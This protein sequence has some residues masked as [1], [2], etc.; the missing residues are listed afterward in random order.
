M[1]KSA[2][3]DCRNAIVL[4]SEGHY[5]IR[6]GRIRGEET[7]R[8]GSAVL[9]LVNDLERELK[10]ANHLLAAMEQVSVGDT[11]KE[12]LNNT[13][14]FLN[15]FLPYDRM[16]FSL[17]EDNGTMLRQCWTRPI[18]EEDGI[19]AGYSCPLNKS[20]LAQ[21][22]STRKPRIIDDLSAYLCTHSNSES[23]KLLIDQGIC[24]NLACPVFGRAGPIGFFFFD[25]KTEGIYRQEHVSA[26]SKIIGQL[27]IVVEKAHTYDHR[28]CVNELEKTFLGIAVH[29]L[30]SPLSIIK[31]FL[32]VLLK[33]TVGEIPQEQKELLEKMDRACEC[34]LDL[35]N[36]L[37]DY[38]AIES[39]GLILNKEEVDLFEFLQER[40]EFYEM[41]ARMKNIKYQ[42]I[43]DDRLD[44]VKMD[45]NRIGQVI[46]NL[47]SNAIKYSSPN[48]LI[49]M[50]AYRK[51]DCAHI[52]VVDQGPG[53]PAEEISKVFEDFYCCGTKPTAGERSTGLGLAIAKKLIEAHGGTIRVESE[54]GKGSRFTVSLPLGEG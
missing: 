21:L 12:I 34:I 42:L 3:R 33:G 15:D 19:G 50:H 43:I 13:F 45:P 16:G 10:R 22:V 4:M 49:V 14:V 6:V 32:A 30:R 35:T 2:I 39:G 38:R 9:N 20:S 36:N 1:N 47:V 37:L 24:S 51:E 29:D 27:S 17:M 8:L 28:M 46:Q 48:T 26:V 5:G 40:S 18:K 25:S 54:I 41:L 11:V 23:T 7:A 44:Q 53:I 31:G 52:A